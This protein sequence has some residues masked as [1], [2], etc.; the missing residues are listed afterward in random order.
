MTA[1]YDFFNIYIMGV[2][3]ASFQFYFLVKILKKKLLLPFYF[4][5]AVCAVIINEFLPTGTIMGFMVFDTLLS[6]S[7]KRN[8]S[9]L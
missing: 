4:L 8:R 5:F 6:I 3:E 7:E 1:Y 2:V 9:R